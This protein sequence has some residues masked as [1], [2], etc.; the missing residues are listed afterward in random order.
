MLVPVLV[1]ALHAVRRLA[2]RLSKQEHPGAGGIGESPPQPLVE[3]DRM[4]SGCCQT[5]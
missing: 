5:D 4:V 2:M 1:I 3:A